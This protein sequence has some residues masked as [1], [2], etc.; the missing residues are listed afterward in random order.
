MVSKALYNRDP[1]PEGLSEKKAGPPKK[2][3]PSGIEEK[4]GEGNGRRFNENNSK[5][6]KDLG[7][8]PSK[9]ARKTNQVR[10]ERHF[11]RHDRLNIG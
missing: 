9:A 1:K 5:K 6:A 11:P 2:R 8:K 3:V 4:N 10:R 7:I